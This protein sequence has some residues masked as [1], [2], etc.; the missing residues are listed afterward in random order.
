MKVAVVGAGFAGLALCYYLLEEG[1]S[2][3][4][5]EAKR[6]GGGASGAAVG[7]LHPYAGEQVRRSYLAD[8]ALSEA[9][10]LLTLAQTHSQDIVAQYSGILRKADEDQAKVLL[11]HQDK[12]KDVEQLEK[13]LFFIRSGIVVHSCNYLEGLFS[14]LQAKGLQWKLQN[15][16]HMEELLGYDAFFLAIGGGVF[17][18]PGLESFR[19]QG[20][21]GQALICKWPHHLE[22]LSLSLMGKGYIVPM[23]GG[24]V[25]LGSTYERGKKDSDV[26]IER[27]VLELTPKAQALIPCW[28]KLDVIGG[29]A[30]VRVSRREHYFP[31]LSSIGN[32]GWIMSGL[33]S[34]GLL[35]H[36]Y[37]AKKLVEQWKESCNS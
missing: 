29:K 28:N 9:R 18:M 5:I 1:V 14:A 23:E 17:S 31:L 20:V 32:K 3:E 34:R 11:E 6:L 24:T 36:A 33:G 7:L 22:K 26:D 30:G 27:A 16:S 2:V 8:E 21:K 10:V 19:L 37:G 35:Y 4:L 25:Q 12:Y 13:D 15:I